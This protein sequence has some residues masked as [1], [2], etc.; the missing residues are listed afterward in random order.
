MTIASSTSPTG[1][2]A[3][4]VWYLCATNVAYCGTFMVL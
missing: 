1:L 2:F 4:R 3:F